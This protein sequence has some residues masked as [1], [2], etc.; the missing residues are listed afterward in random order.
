[1]E[2]QHHSVYRPGL[3]DFGVRFSVNLMGGPAMPVE[4]YAKWKQRILLGAS[5]KVIAPTGQCDPAKL[6]NW[7]INR[8][9][10]KAEF[11]Y[12]EQ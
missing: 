1:L 12:S 8:W 5:L 4:K 6:V 11:G 2:Q 10:F 9:A 7:G 3:V